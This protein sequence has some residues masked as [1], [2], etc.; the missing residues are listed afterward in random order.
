MRL[1]PQEASGQVCYRDLGSLPVGGR[2]WNRSGEVH[3]VWEDCGGNHQVRPEV[4]RA[5]F[6]VWCDVSRC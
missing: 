3:G 1:E 6:C 5:A 2:G 4:V